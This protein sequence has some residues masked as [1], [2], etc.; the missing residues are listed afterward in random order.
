MLCATAAGVDLLDVR[1][2]RRVRGPGS[3]AQVNG[4][5]RY[6]C[7]PPPALAGASMPPDESWYV[8]CQYGNTRSSSRRAEAARA[9]S[10]ARGALDG[11]DQRRGAVAACRRRPAS[12]ALAENRNCLGPTTGGLPKIVSWP[13]VLSL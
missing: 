7:E 3:Q 9:V 6:S 12:G 8:V 2:R 11:G 13:L 1:T 5:A 10:T 4:R